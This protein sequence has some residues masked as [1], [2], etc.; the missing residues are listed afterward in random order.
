M[1]H[2]HRGRH[3]TTLAIVSAALGAGCS[4]SQPASPTAPDVTFS[5]GPYTVD[6]GSELV[7]CSYVRGAN[8]AATDVRAFQTQQTPGAHHL[9]VYTASEPIDLPPNPCK[10]GGQPG[11][12]Q[13]L[14]T[15][16]PSEEVTFPDG[17]GLTIGPQQQFVMEAHY[18]NAGA[19][20]ATWT[21]SFG[22][23]FAP[24]GTVKQRAAPF[25][26]G[27]GNIA[28][29][30]NGTYSTSAT[31]AL[32]VSLD[33]FR[34]FGH[35]HRYGTGVTVERVGDATPIYQTKQWD[36]PPILQ[37]DTG[38]PLSKGDQVR[39]SC[40][41]NNPTATLLSYPTEMCFAVGM[42]W[43]A[44]MGAS[45]FCAAQG[46]SPTCDCSLSTGADT[47][48]GGA[49]VV[50]DVS[51]ADTIPNVVGDPS[52][53]EPIYCALFRNQDWSLTGP[54]APPYYTNA[55][56]G[57][58]LASTSSSVTLTFPGVTP[59]TYR[60]FCFMDTIHGG[61]G[62]G[63]GDPINDPPSAPLIVA[64]SGQTAKGQVVLD[65]GLPSGG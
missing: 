21:A 4:S 56:V 16:L 9:I 62:A 29:P 41:W 38:L 40:D 63:A 8:A 49:T 50:I 39:V 47:G 27:S 2:D 20:P 10:Q 42:Y 14:V 17:V 52:A 28:V 6:A 26:I 43:P 35:E 46:G 58:A 19:S 53:G 30:A 45:L 36:S 3:F 13:I 12:T 55:A 7:M 54:T 64:N 5:A 32:P 23:T 61:F 33:V 25:L 15:Q 44:P 51:R 60:A 1:M 59:G 34:I 31:C 57:Q 22:M 37:F 24:S 11:W 65:V 18:I 48:P